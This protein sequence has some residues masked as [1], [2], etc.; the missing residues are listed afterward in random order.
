MALLNL[1]LKMLFLLINQPK[2][3]KY[4]S[5]YILSS[6]CFV[7]QLFQN[8]NNRSSGNMH[9]ERRSG[10]EKDAFY[11]YI[12]FKTTGSNVSRKTK[13]RFRVHVKHHF[14]TRASGI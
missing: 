6:N 3:V 14:R 11:E 10:M 13:W 9:N 8:K 7:L 12:L 1:Q 2:D 5:S 4:E